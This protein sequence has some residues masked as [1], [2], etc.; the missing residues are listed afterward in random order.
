MGEFFHGWRR[1][2]GVVTLPMAYEALQMNGTSK[3]SLV[4]VHL[5]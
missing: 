3:S 2:T 5:N 1:K 4:S